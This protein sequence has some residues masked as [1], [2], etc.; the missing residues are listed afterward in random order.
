MI[1]IQEWTSRSFAITLDRADFP[2]VECRRHRTHQAIPRRI[3]SSETLALT[4]NKA[5]AIMCK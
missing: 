3:D 1:W 5:Y 2:M 4:F